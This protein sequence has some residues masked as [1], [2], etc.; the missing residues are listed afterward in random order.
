V[1]LAHLAETAGRFDEVEEL[2]DLAIEWFEGQGDKRRALTLRRMR[3]GAR[4]RLGE[5][6]RV[7]LDALQELDAKAKNLGLD[8]ERVAILTLAAQAHA[9]LGDTRKAEQIAL[10]CIEMAE[11]MG[12]RAL[13]AEALMRLGTT[14]LG[15][16]PS[17]SR[18]F[19]R[20]ALELFQETGDFRGQAQSHVN[21]GTAA[22]L[23]SMVEEATEAY[24][25]SMAVA[26]AAGMPDVWGVAAMN[27][28]MLT[29]RA[30]DYDRARELLNEALGAFA[31]IKQ[32]QYQL[33]AL[34]NMAHVEREVR[35]WESARKLYEATVPLAQ[36][37]GQ[38]DIEIGAIAGLG[39]CSLELGHIEDARAALQ[40]VVARME[41]RPDWF[42]SREVVEAFRVR[43]AALDGD[44]AGA[45]M[46]LANAL[47]LAEAADVYSAV[48]LTAECAEA[49]RPGST[50]ELRSFVDRYASQ[51]KQLGFARMT[52]RYEE[53]VAG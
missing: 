18:V 49:L 2:C 15:E 39:T 31:A 11:R 38:S 45:M 17:R 1:K 36:R 28:A 26:R 16:S 32:S 14:L 21:I 44:T 9:R 41:S 13:L 48:W 4:M 10:Q 25:R 42:Q 3:E 23:V 40:N 6:A 7:A 33:M 20:Q 30:G 47:T 46:R 24:G 34:Y 8:H 35:S 53:L 19:Y 51:V 27:L 29:G 37:I 52:R 12:D 22:H 50:P 5:P 43:M